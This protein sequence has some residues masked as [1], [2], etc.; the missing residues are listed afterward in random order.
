MLSYSW[1]LDQF[2][3]FLL[4]LSIGV[5]GSL[6]CQ[7]SIQ[8]HLSI[9]CWSFKISWCDFVSIIQWFIKTLS[10]L[11]WSHSYSHNILWSPFY[12]NFQMRFCYSYTMNQTHHSTVMNMRATCKPLVYGKVP[13]YFS[14]NLVLV[15]NHENGAPS[16]N[17]NLYS[18]LIIF[19]S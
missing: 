12:W 14:A 8:H 15:Q 4:L 18:V 1:W 6:L 17:Q 19:E 2:C 11:F 13:K 3:H 7:S 9:L 5:F 10:L 16:E